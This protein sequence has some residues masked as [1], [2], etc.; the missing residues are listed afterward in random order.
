MSLESWSE[1]DSWSLSSAKQRSVKY[2]YHLGKVLGKG[3]DATVR[4]G[5][6][7]V[8]GDLVAIKI[9]DK[10]KMTDKLKDE[11]IKE[12]GFLR[13]FDHPNIIRY[14]DFFIEDE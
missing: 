5:Q 12:V 10:E 13:H 2:N 11:I 4:L 9:V 7:K 3:S 6:H 1:E 8:T 14:I